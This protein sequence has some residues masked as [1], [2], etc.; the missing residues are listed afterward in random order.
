[1]GGEEALFTLK[2]LA[3]SELCKKQ[4]KQLLNSQIALRGREFNLSK[5][6]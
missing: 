2:Q 1:M 6:K 4:N 3:F 5:T